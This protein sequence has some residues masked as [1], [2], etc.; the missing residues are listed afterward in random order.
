MLELSQV[1]V[2]APG[3]SISTTQSSS[4]T[5]LLISSN[6][7]IGPSGAHIRSNDGDES[8]LN[9]SQSQYNSINLVSVK[10]FDSLASLQR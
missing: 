8:Y 5:Y 1:S 3:S 10:V 4:H 6:C 7:S 2:M 9:P